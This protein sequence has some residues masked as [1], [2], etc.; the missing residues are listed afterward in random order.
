MKPIVLFL[1]VSVISLNNMYASEKKVDYT[2]DYYYQ[3]DFNPKNHSYRYIKIKLELWRD[4]TF[5]YSIWYYMNNDTWERRVSS[6]TWR[7]NR[8]YILLDCRFDSTEYIYKSIVQAMTGFK[9]LERMSI[10]LTKRGKNK[11]KLN[12]KVLKRAKKR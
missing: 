10:Y 5:R 8:R 1:I 3:R 2:G 7:D 11:L 9:D 12:E 4:S 6:G